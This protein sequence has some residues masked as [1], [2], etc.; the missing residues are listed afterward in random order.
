MGPAPPIGGDVLVWK[1]SDSQSGLAGRYVNDVELLN[2]LFS[3]KY[4]STDLCF[5]KSVLNPN[6]KTFSDVQCILH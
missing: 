2:I 4:F 5:L 3:T 1:N 6:S